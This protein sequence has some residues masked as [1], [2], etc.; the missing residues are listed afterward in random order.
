MELKNRI[1]SFAK[2][3]GKRIVINVPLLGTWIYRKMRNAGKQVLGDSESVIRNGNWSGNDTCWRMAL[4]LNR[5][6][7][8][9]NSDG[10]WRDRFHPKAYLA[11]AD[12]IVGGQGNGPLC[13]D[14]VQSNVLVSG[15]NPA[16]VDA[17][18]AKLMGFDPDKIPIIKHAFEP[19]RWPITTRKMDEIMVFDDRIERE[20][21]IDKLM[22]AVDGGFGPHYGWKN[23]ERHEEE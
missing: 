14:P 19:H 3:V 22:P 21:K 10:T 4:D 18:V 7:L 16:E 1:E 5:A 11:I 15:N 9:V 2:Q 23:L 6:L 20:V 17:V 12:G 13:P 8:Y